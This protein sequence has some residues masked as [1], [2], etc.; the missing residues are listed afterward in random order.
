MTTGDL[1]G[2]ESFE[3]QNRF[4]P[5]SLNSSPAVGPL[6]LASAKSSGEALLPN[7][8]PADVIC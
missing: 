4:L 1:L 8:F 5:Q 6:P 2:G 3:Q 7:S